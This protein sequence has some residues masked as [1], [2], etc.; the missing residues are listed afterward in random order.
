MNPFEI[1]LYLLLMCFGFAV[2][3]FACFWMESEEKVR[4]YS[5]LSNTLEFCCRMF[6]AL[7]AIAGALT[8]LVVTAALMVPFMGTA[9]L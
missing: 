8:V 6:I 7:S 3:S 2:A 4:R 9:E 1:A 5:T